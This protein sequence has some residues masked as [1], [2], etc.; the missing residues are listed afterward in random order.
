MRTPN[1]NGR[2]NLNNG[3]WVKPSTSN[4]DHE[5]GITD[6][7]IARI[8]GLLEVTIDNLTINFTGKTGD[9]VTYT[10][11]VDTRYGGYL[12]EHDLAPEE[13]DEYWP[14]ARVNFAVLDLPAILAD[15]KK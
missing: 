8:G 7:L 15:A 14:V 13:V 6:Q 12:A 9:T 10:I 3:L 1:K 2:I 5:V 11:P 4:F